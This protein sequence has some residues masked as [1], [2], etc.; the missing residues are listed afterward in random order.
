MYCDII[1]AVL[2]IIIMLILRFTVFSGLADKDIDYVVSVGDV[3]YRVTNLVVP[4]NQTLNY[5]V[6]MVS[7]VEDAPVL[8]LEPTDIPA[9]MEID[10]EYTATWAHVAGVY[11]THSVIRDRIVLEYSSGN[12]TEDTLADMKS[13]IYVVLKSQYADM[14]QPSFLPCL[15]IIFAIGVLLFSFI[16]RISGTL[17]ERIAEPSPWDVLDERLNGVTMDIGTG[18]RILNCTKNFSDVIDG[19]PYPAVSCRFW[20]NDEDYAKY[21]SHVRKMEEMR[22]ENAKF[23]TSAEGVKA[24]SAATPKLSSSMR[25]FDINEPT[26]KIQ[27]P[28]MR[29]GTLG[30]RGASSNPMAMVKRSNNVMMPTSK[31]SA[32]G[33]LGGHARRAMPTG[34]MAMKTKSNIDMNLDFTV[35]EA[36]AYAK[37]KEIPLMSG[38]KRG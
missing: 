38:V 16:S 5:E 14:I 23:D 11:D 4:T 29:K 8:N 33:G 21:V 25:A 30:N 1:I 17:A 3:P 28:A 19:I 9:D 12:I 35:D 20:A 10:S 37:S 24:K 22:V 7:D 18:R 26:S 31:S 27:A 13:E 2:L 32:T 15:W 6:T 34:S 36:T